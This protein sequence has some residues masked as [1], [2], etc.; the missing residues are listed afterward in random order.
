MYLIYFYHFVANITQHCYNNK[1]DCENKGRNQTGD[2]AGF[3][4][5]HNSFMLLFLGA[6]EY[7]EFLMPCN[8]KL[9]KKDRA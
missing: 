5:G 7:C 3:R 8:Y 6:D 1:N 2:P 4:K 9:T